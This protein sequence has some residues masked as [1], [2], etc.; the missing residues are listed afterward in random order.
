MEVSGDCAPSFCS[1]TVLVPV[2]FHP[3]AGHSVDLVNPEIMFFGSENFSRITFFPPFLSAFCS[4]VGYRSSW[5]GLSKHLSFPVSYDFVSWF[6]FLGD[7]L[8][9]IS[10]PFLEFLV[11]AI[12]FLFLWDLFCSYNVPFL[13]ISCSYDSMRFSSSGIVWFSPDFLSLF[14]SW[15][16]MWMF[17]QM[18]GDP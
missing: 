16:L 14:W 12:K 7:S 9:I 17:P 11:L 4:L 3:C 13:I 10:S 8:N 2:S 15:S 18:A 6:F 5:T 1:F